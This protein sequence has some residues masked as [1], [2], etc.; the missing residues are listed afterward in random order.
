MQGL[1]TEHP[2]FRLNGV[3]VL[4]VDDEIRWGAMYLATCGLDEST[5]LLM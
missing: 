4:D 1:N 2:S 3:L 5:Q